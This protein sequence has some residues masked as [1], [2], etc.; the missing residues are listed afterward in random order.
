MSEL[1]PVTT[2]IID[3]EHT[4]TKSRLSLVGAIHI[5]EPQYYGRLQKE[6][7]D[8]QGDDGLVHFEGIGKPTEEELADASWTDRKKILLLRG[9]LESMY[10]TLKTFPGLQY[11][12]EGIDY[13]LD[14]ERHDLTA[15]EM[16]RELP[17][18]LLLAQRAI[19]S[20]IMYG[21]EKFPEVRV[22]AAES[23][24]KLEESRERKRSKLLHDDAYEAIVITRR[25][26]HALGAVARA[27]SLEP[28][29]NLTLLW[30]QGHLA[31]LAEGAVDLG[32]CHVDH[33]R[34]QAIDTSRLAEAIADSTA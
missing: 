21:L 8:R 25:N 4:E 32:Y 33:Q 1:K 17:I 34:V 13:H 6:I 31:G 30:G 14:W 10:G 2:E 12:K 7:S 24:S 18:S 28:D 26:E 9:Y 20:G 3:F 29:Q 11:Q 15:L 19:I 5:A 16:V 22:V 27:I 23:L